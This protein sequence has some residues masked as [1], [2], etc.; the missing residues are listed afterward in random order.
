MEDH[1]QHILAASLGT[2]FL[3][4]RVQERS[5]T[6]TSFREQISSADVRHV[7]RELEVIAR[8]WESFNAEDA[9]DLE[10]ACMHRDGHCRKAVMRYVHHL[11]QLTKEVIRDKASLHPRRFATISR[12]RNNMP[13]AQRAFEEKVTCASTHF[14]VYPTTRSDLA[15][16]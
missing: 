3:A 15:T 7:P 14:V 11:Q 6:A 16:V 13:Y 4:R 10:L 9:H 12:W 1:S 2:K 8:E 5:F